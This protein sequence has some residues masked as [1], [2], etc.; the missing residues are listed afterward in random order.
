MPALLLDKHH[1]VDYM[2]GLVYYDL[3]VL[4]PLTGMERTAENA[5]AFGM[6]C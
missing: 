3:R 2:K 4:A 5:D 1:K 6:V